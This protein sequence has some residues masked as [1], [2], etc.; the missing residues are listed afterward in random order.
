MPKQINQSKQS[1]S[2]VRTVFD[3]TLTVY[4][5]ESYDGDTQPFKFLIE[6]GDNL[7]GVDPD[8]PH[9]E[10]VSAMCEFYQCPPITNFD[11]LIDHEYY[12][13]ISL[14]KYAKGNLIVNIRQHKKL[15]KRCLLSHDAGSFAIMR[16]NFFERYALFGPVPR[17]NFK[18]FLE[19]KLNARKQKLKHNRK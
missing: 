15:F 5:N 9:H 19:G 16:E 8:N 3:S 17:P 7:I 1:L 2:T 11:Q 13:C 10:L 12:Y 14:Q 18:L 4:T 6:S